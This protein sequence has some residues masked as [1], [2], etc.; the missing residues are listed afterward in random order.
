[1]LIESAVVAIVG[2]L[3]FGVSYRF[4]VE[5]RRRAFILAGAFSILWLVQRV[6]LSRGRRYAYRRRVEHVRYERCHVD[7]RDLVGAQAE[8]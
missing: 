1:M 5:H 6:C 3:L 4:D 8:Y 7:R 2:V